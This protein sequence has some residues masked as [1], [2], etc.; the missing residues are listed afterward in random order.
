[1]DDFEKW[2]DL[3][4]VQ[5]RLLNESSNTLNFIFLMN[6]TREQYND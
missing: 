4:P 1:M 5:F 6:L 2:L 3:C